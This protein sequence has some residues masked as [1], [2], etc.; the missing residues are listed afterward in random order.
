MMRKKLRVMVGIVV[1]LFPW[2]LVS[3][4]DE[5]GPWICTPNHEIECEETGKCDTNAAESLNLP[6]FIKIDLVAKQMSGVEEGIEE[7]AAIERVEHVDGRLVLQGVQDG[8]GWSMV[9]VE[10]SGDMT[11]SVAGDDTAW[12]A[13]G[14][15]T[16]L[17]NWL[18][19]GSPANSSTTETPKE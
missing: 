10:Q 14:A 13:F 17:A 2:S 8:R 15:C 6:P 9:I 16:P 3:A 18:K 4:A 5:R 12:Q 7:A 19:S 11:L 1:G